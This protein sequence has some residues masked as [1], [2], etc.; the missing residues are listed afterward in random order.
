M[1]ILCND[2]GRSARGLA[3]ITHER[4]QTSHGSSASRSSSG[5]SQIGVLSRR[6]TL[7]TQR[8]MAGWLAAGCKRIKQKQGQR[9]TSL[10]KTSTSNA[11]KAHNPL[12]AWQAVWVTSLHFKID[13]YTIQKSLK[14]RSSKQ[15]AKIIGLPNQAIYSLFNWSFQKHCGYKQHSLASTSRECIKEH[16]RIVFCQEASPCPCPY[17]CCLCLGLMVSSCWRASKTSAW[18]ATYPVKELQG[19]LKN[20]ASPRMQDLQLRCAM[21]YPSQPVQERD[22]AWHL[23]SL[24]KS[25]AK[26]SPWNLGISWNL[27]KLPAVHVIRMSSATL[28][29]MGTSN[30]GVPCSNSATSNLCHEL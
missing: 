11:C 10:G 20:T 26:S 4:M 18:S 16:F 9:M 7:A 22:P 19:Q 6:S 23:K 5:I 1:K 15:I 29:T 12:G 27:Q 17:L 2:I 30:T 25:N 24:K 21:C 28:F 14:C 8:R 13:L 3:R